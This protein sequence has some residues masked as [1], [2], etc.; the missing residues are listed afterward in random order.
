MERE[1]R[2]GLCDSASDSRAE[3]GELVKVID[4]KS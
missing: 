3:L 1:N 4:R 2:P